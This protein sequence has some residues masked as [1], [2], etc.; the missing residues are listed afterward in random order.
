MATELFR[1]KGYGGTS[2]ED[3]A[4]AL[5]ILKGSLYYY[6]NSKEDL[7]FEI[8]SA[9]HEDVQ[10]ILDDSLGRSDLPPLE[11]VALYVREQVVY[12]VRNVA[13]IS[14]YYREM[15]Q[16]GPE[17]RDQVRAHR[18]GQHAAVA[19]MLSEAQE[20]GEIASEVD[21]ALASHSVFATVNWIYTWWRPGGEATPDQVAT[22]CV[23]FVLGGISGFASANVSG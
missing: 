12:N 8:V 21:I 17:L 13:R 9:V 6:M 1:E 3:I 11:R 20:G 18:R 23:D 10:R 4:Q 14:V 22:S 7:L 16:L 15:D 2:M 5:G 19:A